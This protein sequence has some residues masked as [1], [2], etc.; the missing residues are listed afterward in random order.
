LNK[1][2]E[3]RIRQLVH[4]GCICCRL[5]GSMDMPAEI[6][7]LLSG[8]RRRGHQFTIPLCSWHHRAQTNLSTEHAI[9]VY[10]PS[11][12][13]G[14]KPFHTAFGSDDELLAKVN[15]LI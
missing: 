9:E 2:D 15:A 11:V 7:H 3:E 4:L 1:A 13:Q 10:G 5:R 12:A 14:S 6:H 8:N